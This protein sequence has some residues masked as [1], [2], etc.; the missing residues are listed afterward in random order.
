[1]NNPSSNA[2]R[3]I[4]AAILMV[5][6]C[7]VSMGSTVVFSNLV[8]ETAGSA[9]RLVDSHGAPLA[10][11]SWIRLGTF[12][13]LGTAEIA[14]L[15]QQ[16]PAVLLAAFIPFGGESSIGIGANSAPGR[17]E[18]AESA[19]LTSP[20][21]GLQAVL[22]NGPSPG[23][24][25]EVLIASLPGIAPPDDASGLIGYLAV[26]L[27]DT[28]LI[29]GTQ[30][31]GEFATVA[32]VTAGFESWMTDHTSSGLSP[33]KLLPNADADGDG[34]A[35]LLEYG[36]G[37][38]PGDA[39]S[40][41]VV[42]STP[43]NGILRIR[44]LSRIDD[45]NLALFLQT[46]GN[47]LEGSWVAATTTPEAVPSPSYPAPAGFEW[48]QQDLPMSGDRLFTRLRATLDR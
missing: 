21:P 30:T 25:T 39:A 28:S 26:H 31:A 1:M 24:A 23:T 17:I 9:S 18:F 10:A 4:A 3:N 44:F 32:L 14:A 12:G 20:L 48:L 8:A 29:V 5:A 42:E 41:P 7:G 13:N 35:N 11:G 27:E 37:T 47:L 45:P 6:G 34:A 15:A 40:H 2:F 43:E 33:E 22:L 16:G 38:L 19:P 36:L 46:S